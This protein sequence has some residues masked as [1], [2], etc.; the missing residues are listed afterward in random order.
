MNIDHMKWWVNHG[1]IMTEMTESLTLGIILQSLNEE[2]YFLKR[3][4]NEER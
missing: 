4:N 3:V 1:Y 2:E